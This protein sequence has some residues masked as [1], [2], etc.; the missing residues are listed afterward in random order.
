MMAAM[1]P[2]IKIVTAA[3]LKSNCVFWNLI[4]CFPTAAAI[5]GDIARTATK[6]TRIND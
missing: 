3:P 5:S 2:A 6:V 4:V 1:I